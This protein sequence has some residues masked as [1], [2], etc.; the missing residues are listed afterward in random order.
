MEAAKLGDAEAYARIVERYRNL[1]F[2]MAYSRL[3]NFDDA[4][5]VAQEVF[6]HAF[7]GI[8]RLKDDRKLVPWLRR[9]TI[10]ACTQLDS[11]YRMAPTH[12]DKITRER[13]R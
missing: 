9:I 6:V 3:G 1:V 12:S 13:L 11:Y 8:G 5:D 2:A 4:H 10:N 7:V